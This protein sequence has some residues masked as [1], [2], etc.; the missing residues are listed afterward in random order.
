MKTKRAFTLIEL[1]V[2]ISIVALLMAVLLPTLAQV[3]KQA[4]ASVC[5]SNLR[6]WGLAFAAYAADNEGRVPRLWWGGWGAWEYLMG[7]YLHNDEDLLLCP[8]AV[9]CAGD[10][11]QYGH[12][13]KSRAWYMPSL[14]GPPVPI[15]AVQ[16]GSYGFNEWVCCWQEPHAT[17]RMGIPPEEQPLYRAF[18]ARCWQTCT[19]RGGDRVPVVFDCSQ[20]GNQPCDRDNPPAYDGDTAVESPGAIW[21]P[22]K[23]TIK[24][25]C[26]DRHGGGTNALFLDWSTRR[27]GLK[28]LWTFKWNREYNTSNHWTKAGGVQAE[29]WPAW[30]GRFKDY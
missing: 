13:S 19:E 27:I 10:D 24:W 15:P 16:V 5:Q 23:H 26:I 18:F 28:E 17:E 14:H 1:L 8:L 2:V 4:K 30:M 21:Q 3:R 20:P 9:R 29:D 25:A 6:Q 7:S 12:G 11:P 22:W